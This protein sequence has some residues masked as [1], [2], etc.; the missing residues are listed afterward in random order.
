MT[1]RRQVWRG[2]SAVGSGQAMSQALGLT[3][4]IILARLLSPEN[5]GVAVALAAVLALVDLI[6][7]LS[8][9]KVLI[10]S[11]NGDDP[12]MQR[13]AQALSLIHI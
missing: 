3:R 13:T 1:M 12:V 6:S 2:L 8:V 10:Q 9:D 11:A 7:D 4:N 5:I